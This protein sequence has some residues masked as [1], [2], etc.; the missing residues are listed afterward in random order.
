MFDIDLFH[1]SLCL[2]FSTRTVSLSFEYEKEGGLHETF[3]LV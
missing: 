3:F 2:L 1:E